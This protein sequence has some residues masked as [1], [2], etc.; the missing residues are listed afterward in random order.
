M[1]DRID[2]ERRNF[3]QIAGR[4]GLIAASSMV[5]PAF[6]ATRAVAQSPMRAAA[7]DHTIRIAPIALEIAPGKII[8]TTAYNGTVPGPPLRL[9][10][11]APVSIH[12]IN[13]SGYPNLVH[14][15][16]LRLPSLQDGSQ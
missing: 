2:I 1:P 5:A 4:V 8:R 6:L 11:G 12:V 15:H 7:A 14:W 3:L 13:D 9:K 16:G 10:T